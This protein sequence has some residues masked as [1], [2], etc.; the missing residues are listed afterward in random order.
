M[1]GKHTPCKQDHPPL[2][3]VQDG[4]NKD[5]HGCQLHPMDARTANHG[6]IIDNCLTIARTRGVKAI[7]AG[8]SNV[9]GP[10]CT[11]A[12]EHRWTANQCGRAGGE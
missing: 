9:I 6:N 12:D 8:Q 2:R 7:D 3:E 10:G 1:L 5:P 4:Q 11:L